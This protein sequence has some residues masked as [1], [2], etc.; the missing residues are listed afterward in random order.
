MAPTTRNTPRDPPVPQFD[1]EMEES[2]SQLT[3]PPTQP[4]VVEISHQTRAIQP[5][6]HPEPTLQPIVNPHS[7]LPAY[8][9]AIPSTIHV[10]ILEFSV[11]HTTTF[12]HDTHLAKIQA[13]F[14]VA[15]AKF[16]QLIQMAST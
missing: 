14:G 6:N 13:Q 1:T 3:L 4:A 15:D 10:E 12:N 7:D 2:P 16:N 9:E 5:A 8:I 11:H